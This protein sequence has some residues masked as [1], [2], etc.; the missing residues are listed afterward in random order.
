MT[1]VHQADTH[2]TENDATAIDDGEG[3]GRVRGPLVTPTRYPPLGSL[4]GINGLTGLATHE[5]IRER[6]QHRP[7]ILGLPS[8]QHQAGG[9]F[10]TI[11]HNAS[12]PQ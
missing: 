2:L 12:L 11:A 7:G 8:P 3:I 4:D 9:S 1:P 5:R 10:N 6:T